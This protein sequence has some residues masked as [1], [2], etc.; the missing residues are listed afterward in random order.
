MHAVQVPVVKGLLAAPRCLECICSL[1]SAHKQL[2]LAALNTLGKKLLA[3]ERSILLRIDNP[4]SENSGSTQSSKR[5]FDPGDPVNELIDEFVGHRTG[6]NKQPRSTFPI[7]SRGLCV[8]KPVNFGKSG[9]KRGAALFFLNIENTQ[10][11]AQ[12]A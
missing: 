2:G 6:C 8:L 9:F 1:G 3:A 5:L 10:Q 7:S 12:G 4:L 11:A